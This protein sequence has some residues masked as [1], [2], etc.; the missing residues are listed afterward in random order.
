VQPE[1]IVR[2]V[3]LGPGGIP[4]RPVDEAFVGELGLEGDAHLFRRHGGPRR[5]VL[6]F[7]VEDY[8]SLAADGVRAEMPGAYG[9]NLLTEG[10]DLNA[11]V[12]GERLAV[13][14]ELVLEAADVR[15]PCKTL[16]A[17]DARFPALIVGRSGRLC[18]VVRP[19]RVRAG[20]AIRRL[21]AG[22]AGTG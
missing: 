18:A 10:L 15:V 2:A 16:R 14:A 4:K 3:C 13:G 20:L 6:L 7:S 9:E 8:A 12:P 21:P 17:I 22:A 11:I 1:A 19:G 5:A